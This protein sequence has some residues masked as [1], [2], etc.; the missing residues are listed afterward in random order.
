MSDWLMAM[1]THLV[2]HAEYVAVS[3]ARLEQVI[4][5]QQQVTQLVVTHKSEQ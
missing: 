3:P 1:L 5:L 4:G 2:D